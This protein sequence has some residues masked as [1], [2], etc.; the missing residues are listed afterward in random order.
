LVIR[1]RQSGDLGTSSP[2][3]G[4][5]RKKPK[6]K[7]ISQSRNGRTGLNFLRNKGKNDILTRKRETGVSETLVL[8]RNG[9]AE[10]G[11]KDLAFRRGDTP[12][13]SG[14]RSVHYQI[15]RKRRRMDELS[16]K[17]GEDFWGRGKDSTLLESFILLAQ[18][19]T[20]GTAKGKP[21]PFVGGKAE[22]DGENY[23]FKKE[24]AQPLFREKLEL[25]L[26]TQGKRAWVPLN[27]PLQ[28][29][30]TVNSSRREG[31]A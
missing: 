1:G 26:K 21:R 15:V 27:V 10:Q 18:P 25:N 20:V 24:R 12:K 23:S 19:L 14:G 30:Q 29:G 7:S 13:S 9:K 31:V 17:R 16:K 6:D 28:V 11:P 22:K 8:R 3:R 5:G 2:L 4:G